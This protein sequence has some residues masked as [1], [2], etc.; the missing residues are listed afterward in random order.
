MAYDP[1][2]QQNVHPRYDRKVHVRLDL[3][4]HVRPETSPNDD[5][6]APTVRF[7]ESFADARGDCCEHLCFF[8]DAAMVG[9]HGGQSRIR[10]SPI[11]LH[12]VFL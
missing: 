3:V 10:R 9:C 11:L 2:P 8:G 6:P 4:G 7:L 12:R 5:V 1:P